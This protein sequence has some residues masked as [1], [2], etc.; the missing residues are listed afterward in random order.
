MIAR[1]ICSQPAQVESCFD[2]FEASPWT[3]LPPVFIYPGPSPNTIQ[4][5]TAT[6]STGLQSLELY[7]GA[8]NVDSWSPHV[9]TWTAI[10]VDTPIEVKV[11][12]RVQS[13]SYVRYEI[14]QYTDTY[15]VGP[16]V[17]LYQGRLIATTDLGIAVPIDTW[18]TLG[19]YFG[20]GTYN[21]GTYNLRYRL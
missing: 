11:D 18:G 20:V 1:Q 21:T 3:A 2:D 16:Y 9:Y 15:Y 17:D 5:T 12:I 14:R 4:T 7:D 6:K 19:F 8:G 13:N 10:T